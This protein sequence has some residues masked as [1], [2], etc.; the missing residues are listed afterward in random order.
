MEYKT[1]SMK[2]TILNQNQLENYLETIATDHNLQ[3]TSSKNT[4]PI[5]RLKENFEV[6]T[7]VYQ[8]LNEHIKLKI[9][10]HPAGEWILDNYYVI[11]QTVKNIKQDLSLRKYTHFLGLANGTYKGFARIYVTAS[12]IVNYTNNKIDGKTLSQLLQAYQRKKSLS[13]EEIWNISLFLK[14]ALIE[15]IREVCEKIYSVQVQKYKVENM[16]ERLVENKEKDELQFNHLNSYKEKVKAYGEMKYPFIE[17]LSYRLKKYGKKAYPFL[18]VLEEQVNKMGM[19]V[20]EVVEKEHF[21]IALRKIAVGNCITSI[22]TL[23]RISMAE[24]FEQINGV[25]D[26]LKQD[27]AGVYDK[28]DYETKV[29]YRNQ[30]KEISQKTK[31]SEIYISKK[32]LELSKKEEKINQNIPEPREKIQENGKKS[33]IGY[34]LIDEGKLALMEELTGKKPKKTSNNKKILCTIITLVILTL[35]SSS[36][37]AWYLYTQTY[38]IAWS[39]LLAILLLIPVEVIWVQIGQYILGKFVKPKII[40]KLDYIDGV[41]KESATF[42]VIPTILT[43]IEKVKQ[44]M[45]RLE[46]YYMANKSDNLYFAILG[47]CSSGKNQKE[48]FDEEVIQSGKEEAKRLNE[49]YPDENFPKFHFLYRQRVWN[50]KEECYLG[51]ERKRGLLNQFNE[52]ILGKEKNSFLANTIEEAQTTQT[53]QTNQNNS[54]AD[55]KH[56]EK[57]YKLPKI[58]YIITLDADTRFKPKYRFRAY[59]RNGTYFKHSCFK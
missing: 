46:V 5:P 35:G 44:L 22:K 24:I 28:M 38:Q 15:N 57:Q 10:I 58:K 4:Y 13:M 9:P 16:I 19:T 1:L 48:P 6:I 12:E 32:C 2:G 49:K 33:H 31:I 25:E 50:E 7:E 34:Y 43:S 27:P 53:A 11:D 8:L 59:W 21:D 47:D 45:E 56:N 37:F 18:M 42:V 40:P 29:A 20:S 55:A 3:N 39:I 51:W 30:I 26:I 52:Y 54:E 23:G 36:L 14:L 17:Y 41:P